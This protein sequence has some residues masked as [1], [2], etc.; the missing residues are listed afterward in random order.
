MKVTRGN[1][2]NADGMTCIPVNMVG[3]AGAGL[4]K[5]WADKY[6]DHAKL[7]RSACQSRKIRA[8]TTLIN[9]F[10]MLPTKDHW[11]DISVWSKIEPRL[12]VDIQNIIDDGVF[13]F[14]NIPKIGCGLGGLNWNTI[15]PILT[16]I[17]IDFEKQTKGRVTFRVF[18]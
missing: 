13:K 9:Q 11:S 14:V 4:A 17:L 15:Y 18:V 2:L 12:L 7:Y 10:W 3:V 16:D 1:I 5:Q 6:P 8:H